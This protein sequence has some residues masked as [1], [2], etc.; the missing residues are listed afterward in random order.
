MHRFLILILAGSPATLAAQ[1]SA[2]AIR[3][4]HQQATA[5]IATMASRPLT[6]GDTML[7]WNPRPGGLIHTVRLASDR[8]QT[9]LLRGDGMIGTTETTW[10]DGHL[11]TFHA[12]WTTRD[13]VT[14]RAIPDVNADGAV[15]GNDLVVRGTKPGRYRLPTTLWG[16]ADFGME[17]QLIPLLWKVRND[18]TVHVAVYR[19]W[20]GRWDTVTAVL[21][22][23][24]AYRIVEWREGSKTHET[25]V[26]ERNDMSVLWAWRHDQVDERRPLEGTR[27]YAHYLEAAPLLR[28][29]AT[30][31]STWTTSEHG[32]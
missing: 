9:S 13:S 24:L 32:R 30:K 18:S 28:T 20:H 21:R 15:V 16:V 23:T 31:D 11:R 4:F 2:E 8:A 14:K 27:L 7:T 10:K 12:E 19:P 1:V 6:P 29:L 17:D 22:D 3:Q 26:V 25:T 5:L